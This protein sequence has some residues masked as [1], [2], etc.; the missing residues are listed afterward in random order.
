MQTIHINLV[1]E[2]LLPNLIPT[3]ADSL[4]HGV[5]LVLGDNTQSER[6]DRLTELYQGRGLPILWRSEGSSSHRLVRLQE[7]ASTLIDWL[8]SHHPDKKW[9]LNATCGTKPM[10]LAFANAFNR[11]NSSRPD[12]AVDGIPRALILYTDSQNREFP[13]LNEGINYALP[14]RSIVTLDEMLA[15]NGFESSSHLHT[16][17]DQEIQGRAELTQ[18]LARQFQS[19]HQGII[20][21][22]QGMASD[23]C[24]DFSQYQSQ[25]MK[26]APHGPNAELYRRLVQDGLIE[27]DG[28]SAQIRFLCEDGCS[29]LAGRW[30]E[31]LTYL[32]A[33]ECGFEEIAMS[34]EGRWRGK[35]IKPGNKRGNNNEFDVLICHNNQLLIIECKAK[36]WGNKQQGD[37][38]NQDVVLKLESLGRKLGGLYGERLL[39][40][41]R[42]LPDEM[43]QRA[44]D[45]RIE[46][47]D[48]AD[49]SAIRQ[50]LRRFFDKM[51]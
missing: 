10:A 5:V 13:L 12:T 22:L 44:R 4:C 15:A 19:A 8:D 24:R 6:A 14:W 51:Q 1:S 27:W 20:G 40:S 39:I 16:G 3:F 47:C 18:Y 32:S 11:F 45:N 43:K 38:T 17:N 49:G 42:K 41:A 29:Y 34:V 23:A 21:K 26:E 28:Q 36:Q 50:V 9:M 46:V 25:T 33:L 31:E 35:P 7:Q 30:L 37:S 2:Q 48:L